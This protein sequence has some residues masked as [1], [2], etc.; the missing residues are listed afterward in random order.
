M[1]IDL[2]LPLALASIMFSLGITLRP[3]DFGR[4]LIQPRAIGIG[5]FGQIIALPLLAFALLKLCNLSGE[6][7]VGVMILALCPGGASAGL[8][9]ALVR[10]DTALSISLTAISSIAALL[11]LPFAVDF[12]LG[13]FL[14]SSANIQL[15]LPR[16][17][18]SV[19]LITALPVGLG[20]LLRQRRPENTKKLEKPLA[21]LSTAL[22]ILIV[23]STFFSQKNVLL[24]NFSQLGPVLMALN[25]LT[26]GAGYGLAALAGLPRPACLAIAMECG[27]QNAALGIFVASVLLNAPA[28]AVPSMVY[29]FGMNLGALG[30]VAL[31]RS[32]LFE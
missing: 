10:G 13:H 6:M 30:L 32:Q 18:G 21:K 25:L 22:F 7:A 24:E 17:I 1:L 11:T 12:A 27:L 4:L 26:M 15:P 14:A 20:M 31:L 8:L 29:A 5:L 28:L 9:T 2:F 19:F 16:T 23:V 3:A